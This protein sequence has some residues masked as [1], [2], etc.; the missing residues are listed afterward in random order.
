M[1]GFKNLASKFQNNWDG[2]NFKVMQ[3]FFLNKPV[4]IDDKLMVIKI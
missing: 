1:I 4:N 3:Q 2:K